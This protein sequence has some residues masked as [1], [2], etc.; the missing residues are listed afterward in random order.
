MSS[1]KS[2]KEKT[3][4][5]VSRPMEL[6]PEGGLSHYLRAI[7]RFPLL[8][9]EEELELARR[10]RT[11]GDIE[12]AHTLV[13]SHLRLVAKIALG[14]RGYGL[15]IAEMI[16]EG[17]IGLM[18]A[19]KK[20]DPD[21]GFRLTSYAIWW[22]KA[23]IQQYILHSW[24]LVKIG[25]THAQKKL[26]FNLRAAKREIEAFE[27]G[28]LRPENLHK[29]ADRLGVKESEVVSMNRR[30]AGNDM[31]LNAP[32]KNDE[33]SSEWIDWLPDET[34]NQEEWLEDK[35]EYQH[36][37][38]IL[39]EAIATLDERERD[40]LTKRKLQNPPVTLK[41]LSEKYNMSRERVR[42]IELRAFKKLRQEI[43]PAN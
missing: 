39:M 33:E 27:K 15:P 22:I 12:A 21:K 30:M 24:S 31:S 8:G 35:Q 32:V 18:R 9:A 23:A 4:L 37:K 17:N 25:T 29:M 19:V 38:G 36:R 26:F 34:S 7:N 41:T 11:Q 42:Q 5:P 3:T 2:T 20:F 28:D 1:S 6:T 13:N 16:S 40:I 10:W 43:R 14:Y